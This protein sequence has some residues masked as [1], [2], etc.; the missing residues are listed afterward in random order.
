M[1]SSCFLLSRQTKFPLTDPDSLTYQGRIEQLIFYCAICGLQRQALWLLDFW[2]RAGCDQLHLN[3]VVRCGRVME[4]TSPLRRGEPL[5]DLLV[6]LVHVSDT[7]RECGD[8]HVARE[9]ATCRPE[10]LDRRQHP[11]ADL[12]HRPAKPE[13]S[14][15]TEDL[16]RNVLGAG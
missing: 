16:D 14:L 3:P 11:W 7:A 13:D 6:G 10:Q 2:H 8:R 5:D 12:R 1:S 9:H 4:Q 15:G